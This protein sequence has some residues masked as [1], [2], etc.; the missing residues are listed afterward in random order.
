[1]KDSGLMNDA[2]GWVRRGNVEHLRR[3]PGA[4]HY[5]PNVVEDDPPT[6]PLHLPPLIE[7]AKM[8]DLVE[9]GANIPMPQPLMNELRAMRF[10]FALLFGLTHE[11][12][13]RVLKVVILWLGE[14]SPDP[15]D[16]ELARKAAEPLAGMEENAA[17]EGD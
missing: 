5:K 9:I 14:H 13:A 15:R 11:A 8:E 17:G 3:P 1:M 4:E 16:K 6:Q 7:P 12:R 2:F 10:I